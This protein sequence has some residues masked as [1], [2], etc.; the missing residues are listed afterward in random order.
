MTQNRADDGAR[1]EIA[2]V[3]DQPSRS[4]DLPLAPVRVAVDDPRNDYV[5]ILW[6][7]YPRGEQHCNSFRLAVREPT[8]KMRSREIRGLPEALRAADKAI[9]EEGATFLEANH[10]AIVAR[11]MASDRRILRP[12]Q[13]DP[14]ENL[15]ELIE[16]P[17]PPRRK[18]LRQP[19]DDS[20]YREVARRYEE[21]YESGVHIHSTLASYYGK[22]ESTIGGW[23]AEARRRGFLLPTTSGRKRG[24]RQPAESAPKEAI[25]VE[26]QRE[27]RE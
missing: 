8:Q 17:D 10:T 22:S 13:S 11:W 18:L 19:L 27:G 5:C 14:L 3:L 26:A 16:A 1:I 24:R 6:V 25:V 7:S 21:A 9:R 23:I 20:H 15:E 4:K 12:D 2:R